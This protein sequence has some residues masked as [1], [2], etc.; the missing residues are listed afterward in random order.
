MG[1]WDEEQIRTRFE[2]GLEDCE[3]AYDLGWLHGF[4]DIGYEI[5]YR[6]DCAMTDY[7]IADY[8]KGYMESRK[9]W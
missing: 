9:V 4:E 1:I 6:P 5:N 7:E 3:T 2:P 8:K